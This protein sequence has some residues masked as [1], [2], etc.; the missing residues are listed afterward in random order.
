[1]IQQCLGD[2]T[3]DIL[4]LHDI[5]HDNRTLLRPAQEHVLNAFDRYLKEGGFPN[6]V[7]REP[8]LEMASEK[9]TCQEAFNDGYGCL[10]ASV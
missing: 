2:D 8:V 1:M 6:V 7:R 9:L 10:T 3:S 5:P 4:R